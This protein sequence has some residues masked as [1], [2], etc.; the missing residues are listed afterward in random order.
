MCFTGEGLGTESTSKPLGRWDVGTGRLAKDSAMRVGRPAVLASQWLGAERA[1]LSP[2]RPP[3]A[4]AGV[5]GRPRGPERGLIVLVLLNRKARGRWEG[6]R[7]V[8]QR[9][10]PS[11]GRVVPRE[12]WPRSR[13]GTVV[14]REMGC[15]PSR[16]RVVP[17]EMGCRPCRGRVVPR[18]M[19][20][21]P[22][23]GRVVP[24]E[25]WC[26]PRRG[27]VVPREMGSR[28][29]RGRVVPRELWS[30]P[31]RGR[32]VPRELRSRAGRGR[33]VPREVGACG[34]EVAKDS[35]SL[36]RGMGKPC[37]QRPSSGTGSARASAFRWA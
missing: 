24:R 13:R 1:R 9:A 15:C 10:S 20:C 22:C 19:G 30:R 29:S 8:C 34:L 17:R 31:S 21:R 3:D 16:G 36:R 23:R 33:V 2:N 4:S 27:R 37:R 25:V 6:Q 12:L 5:N 26:C 7:A 14:R 32:V 35:V 18:E 28:P 11:R